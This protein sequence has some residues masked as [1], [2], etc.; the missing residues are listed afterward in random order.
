[1]KLRTIELFCG[2]KSFTKVAKERESSTF[3][4]DINPRFFP[5]VVKDILTMDINVIPTPID[6]LWASPPC[7]CFSVASIGKN[8]RKDND[9]Y[10]PQTS[11]TK[12]ALRLLERTAEIIKLTNPRYWFIENPRCVTRKVLPDILDRYG[13]IWKQHTVTY[14]QYGDTR[15]KP[16]D[17]WTNCD[18]EFRPPCKN[19]DDCH[20]R[21]PRGART[22]TQGL[23]GATERGVIPK[24]LMDDIFDYCEEVMTDGNL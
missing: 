7:E 14:C 6:I 21:A 18:I 11:K 10:T 20:E 17:I 9:S 4:V 3:T 15:M 1:M 13:L 2:T 16:T 8:W 12:N 19:G 23:K 24:K 5:D 22:G